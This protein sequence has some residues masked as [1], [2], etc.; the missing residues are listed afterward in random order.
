MKYILLMQEDGNL[1]L[2]QDALVNGQPILSPDRRYYWGTN[3]SKQ[4]SSPYVFRLEPDGHLVIYNTKSKQVILNTNPGLTNEMEG[5]FSLRLY[6]NGN[7]AL[8]GKNACVPI[9]QLQPSSSLSTLPSRF[10]Y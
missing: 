3:V 9:V 10:S 5:P 2:Y 6:D 4:S 7:F 8:Y 1:A